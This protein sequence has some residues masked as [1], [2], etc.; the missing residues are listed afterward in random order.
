MKKLNDKQKK[1]IVRV[2]M[3]IL[4]ICMV[5][6]FVLLP[7]A[8]GASA[9]EDNS[10][11]VV[12][13]FE[14]GK[15]AQAIEKAK[16]GTDLNLI[17]KLSV[18]GGTLNSADFSAI[19]GYPNIGFLEL[20]GCDAENG[21]IPEN[22]LASRNQLSYVSLP[23]NTETI[24]TR[25]L[26]GN[27]ALIKISIPATLRNVGDYAFEGCEKVESFSLPAELETMGT[28][29]FS[30]CKALSSFAVPEAITDIPAYCFSKSC[31]TELHLGPQ[32]KS[33]GDGAFSDCHD[34][35]D[36]YF[37]GSEAPSAPESAFQNLKVT[38]HTYDGGKDFDGLDS[39]FVDIAYDLSKDSVYEPP[40]SAEPVQTEKVTEAA[41][42][43]TLAAEENVAEETEMAETTAAAAE[44]EKPSESEAAPV[45]A[46]APASSGF[47]GASVAIIAVLCIVVGVLAALLVVKSK[48]N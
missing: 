24:G 25:A 4:A 44:E 16:D 17:T 9:E 10:A 13:S 48:K 37:Y 2:I 36:I 27:R 14:T 45:S 30:D 43:E 12:T 47:S 41:Q 34:L 15:L 33:I 31:M 39:N 42:D 7:L 38:I 18:S 23:A 19:C 21:L 1:N 26:A 35:A 29:A 32:V 40:K 3:F 8:S 28:G 20:A 22:A 6:S 5:F 46:P 11:V